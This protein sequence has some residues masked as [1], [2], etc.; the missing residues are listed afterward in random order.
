MTKVAATCTIYSSA[1]ILAQQYAK[2]SNKKPTFEEAVLAGIGRTD[3]Q[4]ADAL[5]KKLDDAGQAVDQLRAVKS[6]IL[7]SRKAD[8]AEKVKR[9]KQEIQ[10]L[11]TMGGD[12]RVIARRIAQLSRELAAAAREY[13]SASADGRS[14]QN[15]LTTSDAGASVAGN[16]TMLLSTAGAGSAAG[17]VVVPAETGSGDAAASGRADEKGGSTPKE[18]TTAATSVGAAL[19]EGMRQYQEAQRQKMTDDVQ[20]ITDD[21]KQK[22]AEAEADRQFAQDVRTAAALLKAL[23]KQQEQ[24]LHKAGDHSEDHELSQTNRVL[25]EAEKSVSGMLAPST[26]ATAVFAVSVVAIG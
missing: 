12:P 15:D 14:S 13:A 17:P 8:A 26:S 22:T 16:N 25:A 3:P 11:K 21:T 10:M 19:E 1:D 20:K 24:R 18:A 23:A 9:I 4:K 2:A 5:K 7:Q 6:K